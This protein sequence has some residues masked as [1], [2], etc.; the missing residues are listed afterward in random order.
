MRLHELALD[1]SRRFGDD[2]LQF[3]LCVLV[4]LRLFGYR[5]EIS[6]FWTEAIFVSNF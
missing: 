5:L 3:E 2:G 6:E 1:E 4:V